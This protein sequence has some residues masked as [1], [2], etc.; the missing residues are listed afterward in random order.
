M[1]TIYVVNHVKIHLYSRDHNPP[2]FHAT[3]AEYEVLIE[4]STGETLRGELPIKQHR[5][6]LEWLN[7]NG[8]KERLLKMFQ[9]LNPKL[10]G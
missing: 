10:R 7:S 2:H 3:Y 8:T 1:S 4:I 6:V 5:L 9:N